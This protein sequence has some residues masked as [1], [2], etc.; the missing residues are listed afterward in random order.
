MF[1]FSNIMNNFSSAINNSMSYY[2]QNLI[3]LF[4]KMETFT[5]REI[6]NLL[7]IS[8]NIVVLFINVYS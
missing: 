5:I 3:K 8:F 1:K 2:Y 7:Y 4:M 6:D